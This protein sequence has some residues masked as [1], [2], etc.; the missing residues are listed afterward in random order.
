MKKYTAAKS[1]RRHKTMPKSTYILDTNVYGELLVEGESVRIVEKMRK[2]KSLFVYGLDVIGRE[3]GEVP[4]DKKIKGGI[5]RDLALLTYRSLIDEELVLSPLARYLAAEYF[6][7]Y[8][9]LRKSG[10][11]Y[12]ITTSKEFKFSENDVRADF[13]IIAMASLKGVTIVVSADKRTMLSA[14]A[15]ETYAKV[16]ASNGLATPM[17]EDYFVFR[18][19]YL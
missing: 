15:R 5:F 16:N 7:K 9:L 8:S 19:R 10:K 17:L 13:E 4:S 12:H 18:K 14:I 11:F 2:D 6:T 1:N 3:L